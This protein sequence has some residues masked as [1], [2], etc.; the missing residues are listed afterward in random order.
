MKTRQLHTTEPSLST[1][2]GFALAT[3][4]LQGNGIRVPFEILNAPHFLD[5]EPSMQAFGRA[6]CALKLFNLT[7]LVMRDVVSKQR[8]LLIG[9]AVPYCFVASVLYLYSSDLM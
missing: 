5:V 3:K 8:E 6:A 2:P 9:R 4:F 1:C 7:Q